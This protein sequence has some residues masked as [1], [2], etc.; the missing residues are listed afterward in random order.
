MRFRLAVA[1]AVL[2]AVG[3]PATASAS[4]IIDRNAS[5]VSLKVASNG[6]ALVS[7]NA[8]GK[9]WNVLAWGAMNAT[10]SD[11]DPQADRVQARLLGW[12]RAPT[13]ATSGR[14]SRTPAA[15]TTAPSCS[16]SSPAARR[17]TARTGRSSPGSAR[18]PTTASRPRAKSAVWELR[19][20]H[21]RGE[22][23]AADCQPE[24]GLQDVPPHLRLLHLPRQ[25]GPRLRV[26]IRP[27]SRSTRSDATSTSTRSTRPTVPA[28]SAR[29]A[30]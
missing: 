6:Q 24:L 1:I 9:R 14:P 12:L 25:A 23:P 2:T 22:L 8:R 10:A 30:S 26:D 15:P 27:A 29:T 17:P 20:S 7:F 16:G 19:L 21:W 18:S 11:D 13:S 3:I 5:N 4:E 28:G